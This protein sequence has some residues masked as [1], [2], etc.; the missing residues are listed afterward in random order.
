DCRSL[1]LQ[2]LARVQGPAPAAPETVV[3]IRDGTAGPYTGSGSQDIDG[4]HCASQYFVP[5]VPPGWGS[6]RITHV[7]LFLR[8][9]GPQDGVAVVKVCAAD[10]NGLPTTPVLEQV[11]VYE[12]ALGTANEYISVPFTK[13][14]GLDPARGLCVVVA[15]GSGG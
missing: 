1:N 6:Y 9:P 3:A 15:Y 7:N 11:S 14:T 8:T 10:L 12:S 4:T 13:L 2:Y 5:A